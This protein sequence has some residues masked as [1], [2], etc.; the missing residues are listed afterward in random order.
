MALARQ[1]HMHLKHILAMALALTCLLGAAPVLADDDFADGQSW[2][3]EFGF[4]GGWTADTA[5]TR[6]LENFG[7]VRD[8]HSRYRMSLAVEKTLF[9]Y[10][11]VL[12]QT[13]LLDHQQWTRSSG[14]GP[15]D[16][17][18]WNTWTLDVHA[19][20]FM[21]TPGGRFRGYVQFG[22][23]P[24]FT[25]SRLYTRTSAAPTQSKYKELKVSYNLMG[26]VGGEVMMGEHVGFLFQGGYVFAPSLEN[27]LGDRHQ[28]GG[29]LLIA[30][31]SGRFGRRL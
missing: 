21:P 28:S 24:A 31:L 7:Y 27:R 26:L 10:F 12:L 18:E 20:A 4:G 16:R 23:G 11:S 2:G 6:T 3:L 17:F 14:I 29:G 19:R 15:D 8:R 22:I 13:N 30:G 1:F 9:R 25:P 5:Y